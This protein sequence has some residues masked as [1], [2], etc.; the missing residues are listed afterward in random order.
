MPNDDYEFKGE[1]TSPRMRRPE[2]YR[3]RRASLSPHG[4]G[5]AK[6]EEVIGDDDE[7]KNKCIFKLGL[8][9]D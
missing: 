3:I 4:T 9:Y 5:L 1:R 2:K 8:I 7:L 6:V